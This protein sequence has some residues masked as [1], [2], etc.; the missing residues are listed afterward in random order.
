HNIVESVKIDPEPQASSKAPVTGHRR[1]STAIG[2]HSPA[3]LSRR[4]SMPSQTAPAILNFSLTGSDTQDK[5]WVVH[6]E[7]IKDPEMA[8]LRIWDR[9]SKERLRKR[10]EEKML[11]KQRNADGPLIVKFYSDPQTRS[12]RSK[13]QRSATFPL[14]AVLNR[15]PPSVA[16]FTTPG[17]ASGDVMMI[18]EGAELAVLIMPDGSGHAN[19]HSRCGQRQ[20]VCQSRADQESSGLY[21][22]AYDDTEANSVLGC[23]TPEGSGW[24]YYPGPACTLHMFY[25]TTELRMYNEDGHITRKSLWASDKASVSI[26]LNPCLSFHCTGPAN[27]VLRFSCRGQTYKFN[28]SPPTTV[29]G[30]QPVEKTGDGGDHTLQSGLE[31][32]SDTARAHTQPVA[33]SPP[34][35]AKPQQKAKKVLKRNTEHVVGRSRSVSLAVGDEAEEEVARQMDLTSLD[36]TLTH[37]R[38]R[39]RSTVDEWMSHYRQVMGIS[40]P[41]HLR[42]SLSRSSSPSPGGCLLATPLRL[43]SCRSYTGELMHSRPIS[44]STRFHTHPLPSRVASPFGGQRSPQASPEGGENMDSVLRETTPISPSLT[45]PSV[46]DCGPERP[47]GQRSRGGGKVRGRSSSVPGKSRG[48]PVALHNLLLKN[49]ATMSPCKC[50][51]RRPPYVCDLEYDAFLSSHVPSSQVVVVCVL[52]SV[53]EGSC[54]CEPM[55]DALHYSFNRQRFSPCTQVN[56]VLHI[57]PKPF[58]HSLGG[59]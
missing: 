7:E 51:K 9:K 24:C 31:F 20:A 57:Y 43:T 29:E 46:F 53:V 36:K 3:S 8:T 26:Q 18:G 12:L 38:D 54:P 4:L 14:P 19:Y 42:A 49:F 33:T 17:V 50:D 23:F 39:V 47:R 44:Q 56:I 35:T 25:D 40:I 58:N 10:E 32:I 2:G 30:S 27:M 21:T 41:A 16:N 6:A 59:L 1:P 15:L 28:V 48:C 22:V 37:Y 11:A 45:P 52:S 34:S 55:L 13:H 5:G